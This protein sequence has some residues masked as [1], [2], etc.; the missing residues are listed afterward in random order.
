MT[1]TASILLPNIKKYAGKKLAGVHGCL[2]WYWR[3]DMRLQLSPSLTQQAACTHCF[4]P[5]PSRVQ[6]QG[7]PTSHTKYCVDAQ[8][9]VTRPYSVG[10]VCSRL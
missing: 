5:G 7:M 10:L 1:T 8:R 4:H 3:R 9:D 6:G 2:W